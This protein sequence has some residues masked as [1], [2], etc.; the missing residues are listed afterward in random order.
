MFKVVNHAEKVP[1]TIDDLGAIVRG[2]ANLVH[3][4]E[5]KNIHSIDQLFND[6]SAVIIFS[7]VESSNVGHYSTMLW[8]QSTN[9]LE[10]FD[11]FGFDPEHVYS[12]AVYE[13]TRGP[14][15]LNMFIKTVVNNE[16]VNFVFNSRRLQSEAMD[17]NECGRYAA[18]RVRFHF[19]SL[20]QFMLCFN[21][22]RGVTPDAIVTMM[23]MLFTENDDSL[24]KL[25]SNAI[26]NTK[27]TIEP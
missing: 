15:Y 10:L 24:K 6:V 12:N 14:N 21:S 4:N 16:R 17:S 9:T 13:Q 8:H 26:L 27:Y 18:V 19:L 20:Q 11:S 1:L 23:T 7:A 25:F 22:T 2:R 5:F 3:F